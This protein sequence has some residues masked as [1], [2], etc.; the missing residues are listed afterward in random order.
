LFLT[1]YHILLAF[2][3]NFVFYFPSV[4]QGIVGGGA[5][6]G[7]AARKAARSMVKALRSITSGGMDSGAKRHEQHWAALQPTFFFVFLKLYLLASPTRH[8]P[9]QKLYDVGGWLKRPIPAQ[10][11]TRQCR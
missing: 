3:S 11:L 1:P 10:I 2:V 4:V 7:G 6:S 8:P 5:A 9:G